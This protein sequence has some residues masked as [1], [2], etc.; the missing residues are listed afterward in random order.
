[1]INTSHTIIRNRTR[2]GVHNLFIYH[3]KNLYLTNILSSFL[4]HIILLSTETK[5][6]FLSIK[7]LF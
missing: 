3:S 7:L 1:M 2:N 6:N 5:D 4:L